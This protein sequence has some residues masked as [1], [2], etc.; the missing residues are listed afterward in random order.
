MRA[1]GGLE[2]GWPIKGPPTHGNISCIPIYLSLNIGVKIKPVWKLLF[3]AAPIILPSQGS[4]S[5]ADDAA[6]TQF[7]KASSVACVPAMKGHSELGSNIASQP[8]SPRTLSNRL[9]R[10]TS[11]AAAISESTLLYAAQ[12]PADDALSAGSSDVALSEGSSHVINNAREPRPLLQAYNGQGHLD[13]LGRELSLPGSLEMVS[14]VANGRGNPAGSPTTSNPGR[15][16]QRPAPSSLSHPPWWSSGEGQNVTPTAYNR[17]N[18]VTMHTAAQTNISASLSQSQPYTSFSRRRQDSQSSPLGQNFTAGPISESTTGV[19]DKTRSKPASRSSI[20]QQQTSIVHFEAVIEPV[21]PSSV[22][23]TTLPD[24]R[25]Q[26][27]T[28]SN[29]MTAGD[30]IQ[31]GSAV[32][33]LMGNFVV[34][35]Q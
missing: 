24:G 3:D 14:M 4:E 35:P 34:C 7:L 9:P 12:R 13:L 17:I 2:V 28:L 30:A 11:S 29:N 15:N 25:Q 18:S 6:A 10:R 31:Y 16:L 1:G 21:A 27:S 8:L 22:F 23:V 32:N 19:I 33:T 20:S 26:D 5:P